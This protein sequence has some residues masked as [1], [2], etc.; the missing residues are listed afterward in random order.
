M[1]TCYR[2]DDV[3]SADGK[4]T[5]SCFSQWWQSP[6]IIDNVS[7]LTA[8]HY[9]MAQ[10]ALLFNDQSIFE[11]IVH[12]SHPK[13]AKELG[14]K[15]SN[16]DE[17]VWNKHRFDI[18]VAGNLAKFGQNDALKYYLLGTNKRVLVEASPVDKIWGIGL[19]KDDER[20]YNPLK[21]QGD[22]LLGFAL[23]EVRDKLRGHQ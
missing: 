1:R 8:E 22:N 2:T 19:G 10:K 15:V 23:M 3:I 18:V 11:Q 21:W 9:M 16:F 13:Q 6:F 14:R 17:G 4:I 5:H 20:V 7:Y 12:A